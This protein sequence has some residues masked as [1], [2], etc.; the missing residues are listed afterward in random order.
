MRWAWPRRRASGLTCQELVELVTD[1]SEGVLPAADRAR[2]EAHLNACDGC[3]AY[4]EQ[5]ARTLQV[6]G[7]LAAADVSETAEAALLAA[8]RAW[9]TD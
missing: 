6:A 2:F 3:T 1:Y 5:L 9:H 4:V 7:S 8:F